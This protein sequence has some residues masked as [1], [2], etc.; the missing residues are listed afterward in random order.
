MTHFLVTG[1]SGLLGINFCLQV[2]TETRHKVSGV[3]HQNALCGA[4]FDVIQ[5]DLS[6]TGAVSRVI[7]TI[8][9][10]VVIHC[11]AIANLDVCERNP[12][13]AES[14]N[15]D[16]PGEIAWQCAQHGIQMVHIS[17]DAVFDGQRSGYR[18]DDLPNPLSVYAQTKLRGEQGVS[19]RN[20]EALIARVNFYGCSLFGQRSLSEFFYNSL[21]AG[22]EVMGFTDV[23]FCPLLV[24]DLVTVIMDM[25][26]LRL[27]GLYHTISSEC[28]SKYQFGKMIAEQFELNSELVQPVQIAESGLLATRSPDLR[29]NSEK[30]A[31]ILKRP[32]PDQKAGLIRLKSLYE[33]GFPQKIHSLAAV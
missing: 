2:A 10:D 12:D 32:L 17:T 29:L 4:P 30:L 18:E 22:R 23:F 21:V 7:E 27:S 20:P 9:P 31:A 11:A 25:V 28:L 13:Q 5:A 24:N 26:S 6:A 33:G 8:R 19:R 3:V 1:A 15:V 16:L 14:V